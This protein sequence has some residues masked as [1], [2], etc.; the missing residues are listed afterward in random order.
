[1]QRSGENRVRQRGL[2]RTE[3]QTT[4]VILLVHLLSQPHFPH[5]S[6]LQAQF[7]TS[8]VTW[9]LTGDELGGLPA[10]PDPAHG[11]PRHSLD[12]GIHPSAALTTPN[13]QSHN[14]PIVHP[15]EKTTSERKKYVWALTA[16]HALCLVSDGAKK[17][18][19]LGQK[20]SAQ[21]QDTLKAQLRGGGTGHGR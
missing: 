3:L 16:R 4:R 2:A 21:A 14:I 15:G 5:P 18:M 19:A 6:L 17:D 12:R 20:A 11:L 7:S 13:G 1:M 9:Q 8:T 10:R